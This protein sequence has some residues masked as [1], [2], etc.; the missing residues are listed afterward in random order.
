M[1]KILSAVFAAAAIV[2]LAS[3]EKEIKFNGKQ[4]ETS[5]VMLSLAEPGKDMSVVVRQSA[6][7]LDKDGDN[8]IRTGLPDAKVKAYI[9][10]SGEPVP[11]VYSGTDEYNGKF[12]CGYAP[13]PGDRIRIEAEADGFRSVSAETSVPREA[14]FEVLSIRQEP[15]EY[16]GSCNFYMKIRIDDPAGEKN[17]YRLSLVHNYWY[18]PIFWDSD[19]TED[20][21]S[22]ETPGEEM[23]GEEEIRELGSNNLTY[24]SYDPVFTKKN[25]SGIFNM[26]K[27]QEIRNYFT[28]S[29]FDG[30]SYTFEVYFAI[31][32]Y[33]YSDTVSFDAVLET[34][35]KE[36]YEY[37]ASLD[38]YYES[39]DFAIFSEPV[40][41]FC[42][43]RNGLGYFGAKTTA[44]R[45]IPFE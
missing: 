5:I 40:Q 31:Y 41:V 36:Y 22:S 10:D 20:V 35:S 2:S 3:C 42:N 21:S 16:D 45:T 8:T 11:F 43:I 19:D 25:G 23:P 39:D 32:N 27:D 44:V 4:Q 38:A 12:I 18:C 7:I 29:M 9:G 28:D 17:F 26:E 14:K 37:M 34:M 33:G 6:F 30:E 13:K 1:N 15:G 24:F